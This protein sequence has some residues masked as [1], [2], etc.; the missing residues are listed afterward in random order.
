MATDRAHDDDND[1]IFKVRRRKINRLILRVSSKHCTK[2]VFRIC[3]TT[4]REWNNGRQNQDNGDDDDDDD[5]S[6]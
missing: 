5:D 4:T 6:N 3:R 2:V 1:A